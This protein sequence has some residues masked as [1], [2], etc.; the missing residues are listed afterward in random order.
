MMLPL[1][2]EVHLPSFTYEAKFKHSC[3]KLAKLMFGRRKKMNNVRRKM[4]NNGEVKKKMMELEK[5]LEELN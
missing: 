5:C 1:L 4:M 3:S 2:P